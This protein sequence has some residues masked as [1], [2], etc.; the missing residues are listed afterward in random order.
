MGGDMKTSFR[1]ELS[2]QR[3]AGAYHVLS[4]GSDTRWFRD[5]VWQTVPRKGDHVYLLQGDDRPLSRV[6]RVDWTVDGIALVQLCCR[7]LSQEH[8]NALGALHKP[9][10]AHNDQSSQ[11]VDVR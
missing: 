11:V 8:A 2:I 7:K 1:F 10:M 5:A 3:G 9:W 6:T 4:L